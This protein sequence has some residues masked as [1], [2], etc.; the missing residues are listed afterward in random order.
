M[1]VYS[2]VI[3]TGT[4]FEVPPQ[5]NAYSYNPMGDGKWIP[6][7]ELEGL[8]WAVCVDSISTWKMLFNKIATKDSYCIIVRYDTWDELNGFIIVADKL[9]IN[10]TVEEIW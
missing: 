1:K 10:G 2:K 3:E 9:F 4:F 7:N 8:P 6:I 5:E